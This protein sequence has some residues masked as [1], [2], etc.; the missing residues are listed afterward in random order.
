M[1]TREG[2]LSPLSRVTTDHKLHNCTTHLVIEKMSAHLS[3]LLKN[4]TAI[5]TGAGGGLGR[6]Y[7]LELA[8][9]GA[10][11]LV[12]DLSDSASEAVA[13]EIIANGGRAEPNMDN[14]ATSPDAII[15]HALKAFPQN[16]QNNNNNIDILVNNAGILRD[17]SF[18]KAEHSD[19][20]SVMD[21]H[22]N[23]TY[24]LCK[25]AWGNMVK[26]EY[27]RIVN[28]GSGAGLYGNFGQSSY[29][30]AKMGI[31]GL[32]QTLALEG[33]KHN[34]RANVVV[35]IAAS[36]M[37]KTVLP[38]ALLS[39]L[40]PEHISALVSYLCHD[41]CDVNGKVFEC[42]GGWYSQV[43]WQRSAG[44]RL[45][46][47]GV[48]ASAEAVHEA[49]H[50]IQD[51][52]ASGHSFPTAAADAL[53]HMLSG[54]GGGGGGSEVESP[55]LQVQ[56]PQGEAV[57]AAAA[58]STATCESDVLFDKLSVQLQKDAPLLMQAV[59]SRAVEF[60]ITLPQ[61]GHKVYVMD[62]CN[63][64][65]PSIAHYASLADAKK[66]RHGKP[67]AELTITVSDGDFMK[68]CRGELS[69]EWAYATG[70]MEVVGSMGVA[71]KMK[72]LLDLAGKL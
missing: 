12:N 30:A 33:E 18:S 35:P 66:G 40:E 23:G 16:N 60:A 7:A 55:K 41:S 53:K 31:V 58:P 6:A 27:G 50:R 47:A 26:N 8:R 49:I 17:K 69:T 42:G 1:A 39:M 25:E 65:E 70:K 10:N 32:T 64:D 51:F 29:S 21:V 67:T 20:H 19:W 62:F 71:L 45:G 52:D 2:S 63:A 57:A 46:R 61:G 56:P 24:G 4:R 36:D 5:V 37:T 43:R 15:A 72:G 28:V 48:P 22:L 38:E 11:V 54:G 68:L 34:I 14:V 13:A 59:G 3:L 9:R 44:V